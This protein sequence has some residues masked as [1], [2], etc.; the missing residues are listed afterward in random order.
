[1]NIEQE[2]TFIEALDCL[3][4]PSTDPRA[5]YEDDSRGFL[6]FFTRREGV[7]RDDSKMEGDDPTWGLCMMLA[8]HSRAAKDNIDRAMESL[9]RLQE[10]DL[11]ANADPPN[12]YADETYGR[13]RF[14]ALED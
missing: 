13:M 3:P 6:E 2:N 11:G 1:V 14:D 7:L 8:D 4:S 10:K 12:V 5:P 9:V